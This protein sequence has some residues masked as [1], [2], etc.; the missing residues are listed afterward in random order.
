MIVKL[1]AISLQASN[2][3]KNELL[4]TY[5]SRILARFKLLFVLFLGII[6]WKG[7]S[8]FNGESCFSKKIVRWGGATPTMGNL[9]HR[10][11]ILVES[12]V[13]ILTEA[14]VNILAKSLVRMLLKLLVEIL[15]KSMVNVLAKSLVN[16]LAK[17]PVTQPTVHHKLGQN[18]LVNIFTSELGNMFT[19]DLAKMTQPW[20][21]W[22]VTQ[23]M[24]SPYT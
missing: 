20:P 8:C 18:T 13:N 19:N 21:R 24:C 23:P 3:T 1:L 5:F 4:Q 9:S 7:V 22:P 12:L 2:F 10:R 17:S 11:N 6:S 15:T 16:M 14:L